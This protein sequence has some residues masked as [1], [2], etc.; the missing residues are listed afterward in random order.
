MRSNIQTLVFA[1]VGITF[2]II[3]YGDHP[4]TSLRV[5]GVALGV[6]GLILF[7]IARI[8][9]GNSFTV[10]AE[11]KELVTSGLYTRIRHPIYIFGSLTLA[12][13]VLCIEKP[14]Y[15]LVFLIFVP[16]QVHRVRTE[17]RVLEGKFGDAYL[18]YKARTWF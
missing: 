18:H 17:E 12:G 6:P 3:A 4:W 8:Q 9:L 5:L 14:W 16:L 1:C 7:L 10:K 11:A 13:L 15:L 2:V